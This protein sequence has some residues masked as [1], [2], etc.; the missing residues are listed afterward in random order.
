MIKLFENTHLS[1]HECWY[2]TT[3][4]LLLIRTVWEA[5]SESEDE[6]LGSDA[7]TESEGW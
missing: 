7:S 4:V 1:Y 5:E 6:D 2:G 3:S